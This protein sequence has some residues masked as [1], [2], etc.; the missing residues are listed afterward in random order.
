MKWLSCGNALHRFV[1]LLEE[2]KLFL[3]EKNRIYPELSE[4]VW[5]NDL[6][7]F[8]DFSMHYNNLNT[9]LQSCGNIALSMFEDVK[10]FE[11][12]LAV[13]SADTEKDRLKYFSQLL[14]HFPTST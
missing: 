1:E 6:H 10:A 13:F 3:A 9:K 11:K 4:A 8:A 2:V 7:F 5:L 14:K 12:K